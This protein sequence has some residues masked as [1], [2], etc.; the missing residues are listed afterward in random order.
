[1]YS[2]FKQDSRFKNQ[3]RIMISFILLYGGVFFVGYW[4][5]RKL[6]SIPGRQECKKRE[7]KRGDKREERGERREEKRI[8]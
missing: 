5:G 8:R 6:V 3:E 1:M 2:R 4:R 7:D